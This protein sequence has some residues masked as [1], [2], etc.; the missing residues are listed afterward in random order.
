VGWCPE[1][2]WPGTIQ[3]VCGNFFMVDTFDPWGEV[4]YGDFTFNADG[5]ITVVGGTNYGEVWTAVLT[6]Q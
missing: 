6:K 3:D 4:G 5:T 2:D 1:G